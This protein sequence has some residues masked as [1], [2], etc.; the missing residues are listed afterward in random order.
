MIRRYDELRPDEAEERE[1]VGNKLS[2]R[3][4]E[5]SPGDALA[6]LARDGGFSFVPLLCPP[7]V[8]PLA[9]CLCRGID[10]LSVT[11]ARNGPSSSSQNTAPQTWVKPRA[12]AHSR[13]Q[14]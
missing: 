13:A 5:T 6:E 7:R 10:D 3:L 9:R 14:G 1:G 12:A 4:G 11:E 2:R 8:S